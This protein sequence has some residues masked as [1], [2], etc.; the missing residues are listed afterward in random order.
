[1]AET[2]EITSIS[3]LGEEGI[4]E[5]SSIKYYNFKCR[6]YYKRGYDMWK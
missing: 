3:K 5:I 1:M 6:K 2:K 4:E